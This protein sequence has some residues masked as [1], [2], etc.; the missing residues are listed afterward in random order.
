MDEAP[1]HHLV[2]QGPM[3]ACAYWITTDD[4]IRLRVA[5][6]PT[7]SEAKGT[8]FLF[9]GRT[10]NIEK[11]GL[12]VDALQKFG[13]AAFAVDWRGQGLS[14]RLTDD[15]M[16]G[17]VDRFSD[18]QRDVVAV[19]KAANAL[20]LPKP[21]FLIGH[22]IGACIGLR[23]IMEGMP[24]S[25]CAFT[26]PLWDINLSMPQRIGAWPLTWAAQL[27]G[28]G[29]T[30]APGTRGESYVLNAA[31]QDNRLTHDPKMYQY[32][33][34]ISNTL[35]EQQLGGPSMGWLFQTLRETR[36]LSRMPSPDIPCITFCGAQDQIVAIPAARERMSRWSNGTFQLVENA[37]HDI[38]YELPKVRNALISEVCDLF[39]QTQSTI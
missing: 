7:V 4:N 32:Y 19:L 31:F 20:D 37:K 15:P 29:R 13:Y 6:W 35:V 36:R 14:D 34:D 3:S 27:I 28:K 39:S 25:A 38:L 18:Y 8:I 30:Y 10:E 2:A 33:I 17:H 1:F 23:A 21:W 24:I 12:T 26:A 9:Q 22:S 16:M 5:H 11:Y